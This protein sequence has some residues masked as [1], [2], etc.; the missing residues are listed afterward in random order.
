MLNAISKDLAATNANIESAK[1]SYM[2]TPKKTTSADWTTTEWAS[3]EEVAA[4]NRILTPYN[5]FLISWDNALKWEGDW[6]FNY[7]NVDNVYLQKEDWDDNYHLYITFKSDDWWPNIWYKTWNI[8]PTDVALAWWQQKVEESLQSNFKKIQ[9]DIKEHWK[10]SD[11]SSRETVQWI[12]DSVDN[13]K[14]ESTWTWDA[15]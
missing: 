6:K 11:E 2:T 9:M 8:S 12:D 4:A 14:K 3:P 1:M 7:D 5:N 13:P 15:K 10:G